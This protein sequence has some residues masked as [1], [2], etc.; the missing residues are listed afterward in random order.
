MKV[1]LGKIYQKISPILGVLDHASKLKSPRE[2]K[3]IFII[4]KPRSGSTI[5]YQILASALDCIYFS[6]LSN[7]MYSTP[8]LGGS[9][10]ARK[11]NHLSHFKS[12]L[13]FV[14]G[15]YGEAEG[16]TFWN[17]WAG[18]D[19]FENEKINK[20][21]LVKLFSRLDKVDTNGKPFLFCYLPHIFY[22]KYLIE[23]LGDRAIF[24]KLERDLLST[25]HSLY[26]A[27]PNALMSVQNK[28]M[29]EH[30][31]KTMYTKIVYQLYILSKRMYQV[32]H[33]EI[34]IKYEKL[35]CNVHQILRRVHAELRD[36]NVPCHLDLAGIPDKLNFNLLDRTTSVHTNHLHEAITLINELNDNTIE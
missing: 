22:Q 7:V 2:N 6:N 3:Y 15:I 32:D 5:T 4:S 11:E 21:G 10:M 30:S 33:Q 28:V 31:D 27:S 36:Y 18:M 17:Y 26:N 35:C 23:V 1:F 16:L 14:D 34:K 9:L 24:I 12:K 8:Y 13:G 25:A 29:L 19:I 20:K